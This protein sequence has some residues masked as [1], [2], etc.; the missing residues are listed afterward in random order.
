MTGR[1]K[2]VITN[3]NANLVGEIAVGRQKV[4]TLAGH[5]GEEKDSQQG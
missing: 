4:K 2:E 3:A 5:W 1:G